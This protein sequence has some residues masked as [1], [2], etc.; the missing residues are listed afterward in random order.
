MIRT[1]GLAFMRLK[2]AGVSGRASGSARAAFSIASVDI[3]RSILLEIEILL[4]FRYPSR[5]DNSRTF[6]TFGISYKQQNLTF[7]HTDDDEAFL[8]VCLPIVNAVDSER[9]IEHCFGQF[10]AHPVNSEIRL[11]LGLVPFKL[12]SF[13]LMIL[14]DTSSAVTAYPYPRARFSAGFRFMVRISLCK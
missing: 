4:M 8:P 3:G 7:R 14:R 11:S 10:K 12:Q 6:T 2:S 1:R 5:R 9:V 13:N